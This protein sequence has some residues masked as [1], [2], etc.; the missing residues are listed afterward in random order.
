M[1]PFVHP[2]AFAVIHDACLHLFRHK[3][4]SHF[5]YLIHDCMHASLCTPP[6]AFAVIHDACLHPVLD[7]YPISIINFNS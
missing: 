4:I 1:H 5:Y 7:T 2:T 3:Y 6:M